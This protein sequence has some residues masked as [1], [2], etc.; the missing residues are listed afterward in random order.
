MYEGF[1]LLT[2][3]RLDPELSLWIRWLHVG[4]ELPLEHVATVLG[5]ELSLVA[6]WFQDKGRH[7]SFVPI[8]PPRRNRRPGPRRL[9]SAETGTRIRVLNALGYTAVKIAAILAIDPDETTDFLRRLEPKRCA[10]LRR[11]RLRN[12]KP[13]PVRLTV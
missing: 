1:S 5:R 13:P 2:M 3:A 4:C 6:D 8:G 10:A 7:L 11:P 12:R 9:I